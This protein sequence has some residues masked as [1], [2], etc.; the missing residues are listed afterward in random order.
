MSV[1]ITTDIFCDSI[2]CEKYVGVS[3]KGKCSPEARQEARKQGWVRV[4]G[5][6]LCPRHKP[7]IV[8]QHQTHETPK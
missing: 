4:D 7:L 5:M 1:T 6:D 8:P 3:G 2:G